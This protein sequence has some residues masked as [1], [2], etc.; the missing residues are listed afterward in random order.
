MRYEISATDRFFG[1][2]LKR[3]KNGARIRGCVGLR[4]SFVV[5]A[6]ALTL[7]MPMSR[8]T[9]CSLLFLV[10]LAFPLFVH[11]QGSPTWAQHV[12]YEM[13]ITLDTDTHRM[14]GEQRL[15]YTNNS[16]D[17]LDHVYY[18]LFFNAFH[19]NS[20]M[21]ERNRHLPDP[22]G[23]IV[24]RIWNLGPDEIGYHRVETLTQ[25]GQAVSFFVEDTILRAELARPLPPGR[26]TVFEMTFNSQV[27]L[28]TR[29]SGRDNLEGIDYSMAQWYPKI[30]GYDSRGWHADPYVGR[31]FFA[32]FGSY[33]VRLT[34]PAHY[35]IGST[36]VLQNADEIG[37]G[38]QSDPNRTYMYDPNETLTWHFVAENVHDFCWAADPDY[39][40]EHI[41]GEDGVSY[42][43]LYQPDVAQGWQPMKQWVPQLIQFFGEHIGPYP[44][45]QFTVAQAGDGGMEY[46]MINL[47]TGRRSPF[48]LAGVTAHEAAHE[49]FYGFIGSNEADYSWIDEGFVSYW[50]TESVANLF[51]QPSGNHTGSFL[52]T[53]ATDLLGTRDRFSTPA[54]WF[55]TNS[56]FGTAS[57]SG[58]QMIAEMLG[59]VISDE[60]RDRWW[61]EMYRRHLFRHINPYDIE[62]VAED[63]SGLKLDWYFE[64][65]ANTTRRLDYAIDGLASNRTGN[66]WTTSVTL[67]RKDEIVM[68]ADI[69]LTLA[70]GSEQW[71]HVPLTVSHGHKPVPDAWIVADAWG[72]TSPTYTFTIETPDQ[73]V[74]AELDPLLKTP[75]YNRLNNRNRLPINRQF[76]QPPQSSWA[77]YGI[78]YRPLA[79]Y[80]HDYGVAV[81]AQL[82]GTYYF[83]QHQVRL[84]AKIWP[85]ALFNDGTDEPMD[86]LD[87]EVSYANRWDAL[88]Q[89]A[90]FALTARKHLSIYENRVDFTKG[91]DRV[92]STSPASHNLAVGLVHQART[93]RTAFSIDT[94][95]SFPTNHL[96]YATA[97]YTVTN[98][99]DQLRLSADLGSTINADNALSMNRITLDAQKSFIFDAY[100]LQANLRIG[101]GSDDLSYHKQYRLG[102][103]ALEQRWQDDTFRTIAATMDDAR[104]E[105]HWVAFGTPGPVAYALAEPQPRRASTAFYLGGSG[106]GTNVLAGSLTF[107]TPYAS[108]QG[109]LRPLSA[110]LFSGI[111]QVWGGPL[112]ELF[113]QRNIDTGYDQ[114]VADAG[115]G[116]SYDVTRIQKLN[117]WVQQ[118]DVLSGLTLVAKFPLWV[119]E[120]DLMA[121]DEEAFAFRWLLGI[122]VGL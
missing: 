5:L 120:P 9:I 38:Y 99:G 94:V 87:Y 57:Y 39:I 58:G 112:N 13:D 102:L 101:I 90:R 33:D 34:L 105:G 73:A 93:S 45:P 70:D 63:V 7:T 32:P 107:T 82:R 69:R 4:A 16:P 6:F 115:L 76:L 108:N 84:M 67:K 41:L 110:H 74:L 20:M 117:R 53:I 92:T 77:S 81:G 43:L 26:S 50:T 46:P 64:Q 18:H 86:G 88:G 104:D 36:G 21:A 27:P 31:E 8:A 85:D 78:G 49:W 35:I 24:P 79:Q 29:R 52:G 1:E 103:G 37:H 121:G 122:D 10:L 118:S 40:H 68:P 116:L 30:A 3:V 59:Y 113:D 96:A 19:P 75:D 60:L 54:D 14:Q 2:Y 61:K 62:K 11:A 48:S 66:T 42:H 80:A 111:G 56:G 98:G 51:G 89:Q 83:N 106:V 23:R 15:T 100:R 22:D 12:A 114:F 91:F 28:Q 72:W 55:N 25:D 109:L 71:V 47:I 97:T 95:P 65:W 119:S 17:T 44:Y